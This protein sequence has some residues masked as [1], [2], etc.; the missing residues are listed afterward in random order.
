MVSS[1]NTDFN[2]KEANAP[3]DGVITGYGLINN[4]TVYV[5]SQ[6]SSV[7]KGSVGEMHA[8]KIINLYDLALKTGAPVIGLIDSAGLRLQEAMDSLNAFGEIY[9]KQAFA[10]G[11]IPQITAILG[12]C[13]GGLGI[14]SALSDFTFMEEK[15]RL[16]VNSPNALQGNHMEDYD[17]SAV[18]FQSKESGVVDIVADETMIFTKMRELISL[19]PSN[20]EVDMSSAPCTDD[21]NRNIYEINKV[22]KDSSTVLSMISDNHTFLELKE[23]HAREMVTAFIRLNGYTVGAVANCSERMNHKNNE[24]ETYDTSLT[25]EGCEKAADFITFCDAF[26]IPVLSLTNVDGFEATVAAEKRIAKAVAKLTYAFASATVPKV[27]VI[28]KKA[29]GSSYVAM[30]S[31]SIGADLTLAWEESC[32]G[33]MD[34]RDAARIILEGEGADQIDEFAKK[35]KELQTSVLSAAKHGYVDQIIAAED[36]RKYV[37]GAFELLYAKREERPGK[38]HG[39]I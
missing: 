36:T 33:M 34:A 29:F 30:N 1:R 32:I 24:K 27:N 35:Y 23:G 14:M 18:S 17:T 39:T 3:G 38:K 21:L 10:S 22:Y 11:V 20:N 6:D 31:K 15:G 4:A 19:L 2:T 5:Y 12:P 26:S 7:L 13:G 16:F 8:K 9:R 25:V 28:L 37:I